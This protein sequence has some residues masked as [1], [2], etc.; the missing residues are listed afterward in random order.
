[1][2]LIFVRRGQLATFNVLVERCQ[3]LDDVDVRWDRRSSEERRFERHT[4]PLDRRQWERRRV[5]S[6][7]VD[8]RGYTI[9]DVR[10]TPDSV[11]KD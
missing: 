7:D 2:R 4:V 10:Q 1:M 3:L 9:V 5:S 8:L 6:P 11:V